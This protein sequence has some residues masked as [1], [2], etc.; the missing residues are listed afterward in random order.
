[1]KRRLRAPSPAFVISLIALII[2]LGGGAA[3][4]ASGL[5]SGSQIKN[6]SIAEKK[7]T[8][9]AIKALRG[10]RGPKGSTGATGPAGPTGATGAPGSP[11]VVSIGG[12][13]GPIGVITNV[14]AG[15][16]GFWW[17]GSVTTLTTTSTQSIVASGSELLGTSGPTETAAIGICAA[18]AG[19]YPVPLSP[20]SVITASVTSTQLSYAASGT[21]APGQGTWNVGMCANVQLQPSPLDNN[22]SATG[23]AFVVNGKPVS[24]TP[25]NPTSHRG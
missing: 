22:G 6:H 4:Y 23:Y 13:G 7:L 18:P 21:T 8:R 1:M 3:A 2:A 14:F 5:I 15:G 19:D 17:A 20:H 11:G 12:F 10:Q 25:K 9:K 24:V 16:T